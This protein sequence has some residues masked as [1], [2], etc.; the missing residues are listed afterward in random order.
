MS[1]PV[2]SPSINGMIGLSGTMSLPSRMEIFAPCAGGVIF[3]GA[4]VDIETISSL[5]SG[6][7][8][9]RRVVAK[10]HRHAQHAH[11]HTR[12]RQLL[13]ARGDRAARGVLDALAG[14]AG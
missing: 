1:G 7:M 6:A 4:A 3:T 2:P 8:L 9:A 14:A 12:G 13:D 11:N 5:K 10:M